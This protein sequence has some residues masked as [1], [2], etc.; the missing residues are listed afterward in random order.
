M[1]IMVGLAQAEDTQTVSQ[2]ASRHPIDLSVVSRHLRALRDAGILKSEKRGKEVHYRV[3]A[4]SLAKLLRDF[5]T[6]IENCPCCA[7]EKGGD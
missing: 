1:A 5:A 4:L 6:V 2:V 7:G 3:N